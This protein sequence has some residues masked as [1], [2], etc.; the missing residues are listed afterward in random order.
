MASKL[1]RQALLLALLVA[2]LVMFQSSNAVLS[3]DRAT[4]ESKAETLIVFAVDNTSIREI[5]SLDSWRYFFDEYSCA[6]LAT[7]TGTSLDRQNRPSEYASISA[8]DKLEIMEKEAARVFNGVETAYPEVLPAEFVYKQNTGR[9]PDGKVI[10]LDI[11]LVFNFLKENESTGL[12]RLGENLKAA[13]IRRIVV[14]NADSFDTFD[15]S[16]A[17][18]LIDAAGTIDSGNVS[19]GTLVKTPDK[20]GDY[21]LNR[22][23]IIGLV[24]QYIDS[25]GRKIILVDTGDTVRLERRSEYLTKNVYEE[26]KKE[27]LDSIALLIKETEKQFLNETAGIM[28]ISTMSPREDLK[29]GI[30]LGFVF[31]KKGNTNGAGLLESASTKKKG[32]LALPDITATILDYFGVPAEKYSGNAAFEVNGLKSPEKI[33]YL[34][35]LQTKIINV[36]KIRSSSIPIFVGIIVIVSL[37][38]ILQVTLNQK[39]L[40]NTFVQGMLLLPGVIVLYSIILGP[41]YSVDVKAGLSALIGASLLTAGLLSYFPSSRMI[42]DKLIAA[43][44]LIAALMVAASSVFYP[45]LLRFSILGYS[46]N[47]GARFYGIGNE[48]SGIVISG[49]L[50]PNVLLLRWISK[51]KYNSYLIALAGVISAGIM[52]LLLGYPELGANTGGAIT[53]AS[54]AIIASFLYLKQKSRPGVYVSVVVGGIAITVLVLFLASK[55]PG[56]HL[57]KFVTNLEGGNLDYISAIL[58]RKAETNLKLL[59]YT[60]W[61]RFLLVFILGLPFLLLKRD[62]KNKLASETNQIYLNWMFVCSL[63]AIVAFLFNDSGVVASATLLLFPFLSFL[64]ALISIQSGGPGERV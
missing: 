64:S 12:A 39:I 30:A 59:R 62:I 24:K 25:A 13:G 45:D 61:T 40:N 43:I 57:S 48:F 19:R 31:F 51:K 16:A 2:A 42:I 54:A 27:A 11:N 33:S 15:R 47:I 26:N 55:L 36:E 38:G 50:I 23:K 28:I 8:G 14:G 49:L 18:M 35:R 17:L 53:A 22:N 60:S 1:I 63:S 44:N 46:L 58:Y 29:N 32:L 7:R 20:P 34:N 6:L 41:V 10:F 21:R 56:F 5:S 37:L 9:L 4:D 3:R 52:A